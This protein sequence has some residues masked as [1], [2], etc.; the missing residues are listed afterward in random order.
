MSNSNIAVLRSGVR[1]QGRYRVV[2]RLKAGGMGAVYEVVDERT[3]TTRA[4]K[5]MLPGVVEDPEMRARFALEARV[6]GAIESDHLVRTLDAGIDE[7]TGIPFLVMERLRGRD[8]A[9]ALE[10]VGALPAGDVVTYLFQAA[11]A[12][13]KTHA[14]GIVHRD[15]KPDNLFCTRRDDGSPCI[16]LL[17]F[18]IAKIVS[19][20]SQA[21]Q[22][23]ALGTP[24]Y[25]APE[26][27]RVGA[28]SR[29]GPRADL[30]ALG[31]I[32]YTLLV[33]VAYWSEELEASDSL[34][35]LLAE[36]TR[37]VAELPSARAVRRGS[38]LPQT[39]DAW[40]LKATAVRP[41]DRFEGALAQVTALAEALD[42]PLPRS[43]MPPSSAP[44]PSARIGP[45]SLRRADV[46]AETLP[47]VLADAARPSRSPGGAIDPAGAEISPPS[48]TRSAPA[49]A[50]SSPIQPSGAGLKTPADRRS[51]EPALHPGAS[52]QDTPSV[53]VVGPR[54]RGPQVFLGAG[55]LAVLLALFALTVLALRE[56][57][58]P[59]QV[60]AVS[61]PYG[62][63]DRDKPGPQP[64]RL[65]L[66][67]WPG[68]A[69]FYGAAKVGYFQPTPVE[70]KGF[71]SNFDRNRAFAQGR[72]DVL[73]TPLFDAL[74]IADEGVPLKVILL[75]DYSSGGDGIVARKEIAAVRELKGKRVS[76]EAGS[77][78]HFVLLAA[79]ARSGLG[80]GD[81]ELVNLS[82]VEAT[83][84]FAQ[85]KLDAAT[86]WDPHLS[87]RAAGPG[88]HKLF[89]SK[90]IPGEVID[91][92][93]V[94]ARLAEE[95]PKEIA[96]LVSG[97]QRALEA[98]RARPAVM[99]AT[100]AAEMN[101]KPE[102]LRA[103]LEG[104]ELLDIAKNRELFEASAGGPSIWRSYAATVDFMTR[105]KLLKGA[106]PD[107]RDILDPRFIEQVAAK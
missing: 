82:V 50:D 90:E 59:E 37:G 40:F 97:W 80:E 34:L 88:A 17:D 2:S 25:M 61:I 79:L 99:G 49:G 9:T 76:A 51:P 11:L 83:Q 94:H 68:H 74:K 6:T 28:R 71:S 72:L 73:A 22:T 45:R 16:K 55:V 33:G 95:R 81:I 3:E 78:T 106:A 20:S 104:M 12:L 30:Y 19:R 54:K 60:S 100:M 14:A 1:F 42:V 26:Q 64:L 75:F 4:L 86:L 15:L 56:P 103:D 23:Q 41:E 29:V 31:H 18:G 13:E 21:V 35:A 47:A 52:S 46:H 53:H 57:S 89:T 10:Q 65:G 101:R 96:S 5:I 7:E 105:H 62:P 32:A 67:D 48:E 70:I 98:W 93:I 43:S 58:S 38:A 8:L 44:A 66:S 36:I 69:P 102:G 77:I 39:F 107:P 92:L 63:R 85:G 27:V 87:Q 91:V 84:A 24:L